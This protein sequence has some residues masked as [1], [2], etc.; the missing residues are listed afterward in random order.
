LLLGYEARCARPLA[1]DV[2]LGSQL[3]VGA[4]RALMEEHRNGVM[5]SVFGQLELKYVPFE[6]LVDPST[7]VTKVRYVETTSDFHHLARFLE[8]HI[9]K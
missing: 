6:E 3:G 1:F 7:L 2:M 9:N 8:T 5:V 4:Y